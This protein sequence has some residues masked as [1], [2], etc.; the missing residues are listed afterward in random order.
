MHAHTCT[1]T[2]VP[3]VSF[4]LDLIWGN[5]TKEFSWIFVW[6]SWCSLYWDGGSPGYRQLYRL[7]FLAWKQGTLFEE[8]LCCYF[9]DA[10]IWESCSKQQSSFLSALISQKEGFACVHDRLLK[11][12]AILQ[13][14]DLCDHSRG[15]NNINYLQRHK[16]FS[17]TT[18]WV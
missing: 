8:M 10:S 15:A 13:G 18:G 4:H 3:L 12:E 2:A 5:A 14:P 7:F 17:H 16:N 1:P 6:I 9:G 11:W